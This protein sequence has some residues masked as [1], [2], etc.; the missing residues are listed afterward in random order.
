[1][2]RPLAAAGR[3]AYDRLLG[4]REVPRDLRRLFRALGP[5]S[6]AVDCG[7]NVG[8][9]TALLAERGS[10]VYA[11]EP[12]PH[13]FEVLSG[14]FEANPRVHCL[15]Q[16]VAATEGAARLH[17]HVDA[18]DDPLTWSTASSLLAAKPNVDAATFVAVETVD[19]DAFLGGLE[20]PVT[21]LKL[22]VEGA[23]FEIL[24]RMLATGRLAAIEHV[25]VEMHDRKIPGYEERGAALRRQLAEPAYRHVHLDWV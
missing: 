4:P 23:E 18:G 22:D 7:A 16:A 9:V 25:L 3:R 20:R 21:V 24:E 5:G 1:V 15:E 6:L 10:E 14:R 12:N 8:R 17:L 2:T 13:A 11:F 19:L